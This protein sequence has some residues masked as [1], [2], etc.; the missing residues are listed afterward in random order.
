[1]GTGQR[2]PP[3]GLCTGLGRSLQLLCFAHLG[4]IILLCDLALHGALEPLL[5]ALARLHC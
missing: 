4:V 1:M 5:S 3:A 2:I